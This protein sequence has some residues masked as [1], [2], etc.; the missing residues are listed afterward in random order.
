MERRSR[1]KVYGK[2]VELRAHVEVL[3][4]Y[5]AHADRSGL[6]AWHGHVKDRSPRLTHTW[7]V[8]GEPDAQAALAAALSSAGS[9]VSCPSPGDRALV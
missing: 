4:G 7:L 5:S 6:A 3:T 2:E 1:I 8:H 9:A